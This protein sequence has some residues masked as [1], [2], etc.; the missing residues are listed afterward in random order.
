MNLRYG[1]ARVARADQIT[2]EIGMQIYDLMAG[3][4]ATVR[5]GVAVEELK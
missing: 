5:A 4:E 1:D 2:G 3:L